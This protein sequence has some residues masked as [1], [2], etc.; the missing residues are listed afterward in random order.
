MVPCLRRKYIVA[1]CR[2]LATDVH[3]GQQEEI[4]EEDDGKKQEND[5]NA[6]TAE[7][8]LPRPPIATPAVIM[9]EDAVNDI[10]FESVYADVEDYA[11]IEDPLPLPGRP[12]AEGV[13]ANFVGYALPNNLP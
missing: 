7:K 13:S 6:V 4:I 3:K 5:S 9:S 1:I 10:P 2:P 12:R 11:D 8:K